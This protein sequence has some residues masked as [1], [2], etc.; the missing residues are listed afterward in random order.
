MSPPAIIVV[1]GA[2]VC[3]CQHLGFSGANKFIV[4]MI[5]NAALPLVFMYFQDALLYQWVL[6][7]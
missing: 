3:K 5:M 1:V 4:V 2:W 6:L 7:I